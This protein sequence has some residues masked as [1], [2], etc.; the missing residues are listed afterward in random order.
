MNIKGMR[1]SFQP[2]S[3]R[4]P[5]LSNNWYVRR[6]LSRFYMIQFIR[7][8]E[9]YGFFLVPKNV[10]LKTLQYFKWRYLEAKKI[11]FH[12]GDQKC[13]FWHFKFRNVFCPAIFSFILE[14]CVVS[15]DRTQNQNWNVE[16]PNEWISTRAHLANTLLKGVTKRAKKITFS[17]QDIH[18]VNHFIFISNRF[19]S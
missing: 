18:T 11:K 13:H 12:A 6:K 8:L 17:F 2:L 9:V 16:V 1:F 19:Q 14:W 5:E 7:W 15:S 4:S 10:H 3:W